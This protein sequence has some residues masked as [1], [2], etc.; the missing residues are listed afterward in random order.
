MAATG[1]FTNEGSN[2]AMKL[3]LGITAGGAASSPGTVYLAL[4]KSAI[5]DTDTLTLANAKEVTESGY[6][7]QAITFGAPS[8]VAGVQKCANTGSLSFGPF[9]TGG[10]A[11][12]HAFICD[13][14]SGTSGSNLFRFELAAT[15]YTNL[16]EALTIAIG[17]LVVGLE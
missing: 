3:C 6:A 16:G 10:T 2:Q 12:T 1:E 7:R 8:D 13:A 14:S 4:A 5:A 17:D 11:I 9:A 15:K